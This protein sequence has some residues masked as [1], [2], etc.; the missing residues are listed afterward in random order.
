M[1]SLCTKVMEHP[2]QKP[3]ASRYS[4]QNLI[5]LMRTDIVMLFLYC[6]QTNSIFR[7]FLI[8]KVDYS[9]VLINKIAKC[10]PYGGLLA[11]NHKKTMTIPLMFE[12]QGWKR[13]LLPT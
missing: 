6:T 3:Q 10:G 1:N 7:L 9:I 5:E 8:V 12:G 13:S 11:C 4:P 2:H